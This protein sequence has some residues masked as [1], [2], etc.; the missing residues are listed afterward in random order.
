M[1]A[2]CFRIG[3]ATDWRAAEGPNGD[4]RVIKQR[5][6]WAS[7]CTIIYQRPLVEEQLHFARIAGAVESEDLEAVC[8]DFAQQ[9]LY[10]RYRGC[11]ACLL[12]V[13]QTSRP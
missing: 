10:C 11:G 7:D 12:G 3:G 4:G 8:A 13:I 2:K 9:S 5:G 1:G 6:R